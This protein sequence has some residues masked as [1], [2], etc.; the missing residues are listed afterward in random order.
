M[1]SPSATEYTPVYKNLLYLSA[2]ILV[3]SLCSSQQ[4]CEGFYI[5]Q[6]NLM[7]LWSHPFHEGKRAGQCLKIC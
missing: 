7:H 6:F 1:Q 4:L 3:S 5:K 2:S